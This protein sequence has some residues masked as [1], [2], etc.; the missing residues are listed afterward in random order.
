MRT[1]LRRTLVVTDNRMSATAIH[2]SLRGACFAEVL[3]YVDSRRPLDDQLAALQPDIVLFD[4]NDRV[5][6]MTDRIAEARALLPQAKLVLLASSMDRERVAA[7]VARG[8]DAAIRR[9]TGSLGGLVRAV[10][11]GDVV[12]AVDSPTVRP[13]AAPADDLLTVRELEILRLVAAGCPNG[14]IAAELWIT[15]QTV[16]FHLSNVYRKLG[17][18]N[19]TAASHYAHVN[20]LLGAAAPG[21]A[22]EL[23]SIPAAA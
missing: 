17:V 23:G 4:E 11:D 18:A 10:V 8:L 3:G 16:K 9:T 15:E 20:G 22:A 2:H 1:T 14:L 21:T 13:G 19:R 5:A 12:N 7:A 6:D